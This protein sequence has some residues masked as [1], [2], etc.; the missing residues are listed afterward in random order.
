MDAN[1]VRQQAAKYR[2]RADEATDGMASSA[3]R[4]LAATCERLAD[5]IE[6]RE[7]RRSRI[8]RA[9]KPH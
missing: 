9:R 5:D 3:L 1:F 2:K 7:A 8:F 6:A 4:S